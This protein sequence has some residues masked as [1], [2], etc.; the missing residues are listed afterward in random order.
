MICFF[1]QLI[2]GET[3]SDQWRNQAL[4]C[5]TQK[6]REKYS[7]KPQKQPPARYIS[8]VQILLSRLSVAKHPGNISYHLFLKDRS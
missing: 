3:L 1:D 8:A 2:I 6:L 4:V 7:S 5:N